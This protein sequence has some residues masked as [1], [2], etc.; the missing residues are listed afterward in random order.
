MKKLCTLLAAVPLSACASLSFAPPGVSVKQVDTGRRAS[1]DCVASVGGDTIGRGVANAQKLIDNFIDAYRCARSS[2]ANGR[3]IFEVPSFLALVGGATAAALGAGRDV[4]ILTGAANSA[5]TGGKAYYVPQEK[6]DIFDHA[7][8]ALL[9]IK[10]QSVGVDAFTIGKKAEKQRAEAAAAETSGDGGSV[11]IPY[12]EQ[13][14]VMIEAALLSV[15]RVLAQQLSESGKFDPAGIVA[16]IEKLSKEAA[17]ARGEGTDE[18]GKSLDRSGD[19]Y[20]Q[21]QLKVLK[22]E[23]DKCVVRAKMA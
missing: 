13:Y 16:Q 22:A 18:A 7:L 12:D 21:V 23:L 6:A 1:G 5:L 11:N 15:E 17:D 9:C 14:Y 4:A 20:A 8:D 19:Q 3:Q 2:A 10:T